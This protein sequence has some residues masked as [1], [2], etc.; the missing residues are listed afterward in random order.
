[1]RRSSPPSKDAVSVF[2]GLHRREQHDALLRVR[3]ENAH[4]AFDAADV[5]GL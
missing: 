3:P 4:L 2:H 5:H 1:M